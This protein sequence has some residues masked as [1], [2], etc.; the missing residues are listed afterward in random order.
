MYQ[1]V[2]WNNLQFV[3][4]QNQ[5]QFL[6]N[7]EETNFHILSIMTCKIVIDWYVSFFYVHQKKYNNISFVFQN[8]FN[9]FKKYQY[10]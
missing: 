3:L 4:H 6:R 7:Q 9:T 5:F 2:R 10:V 8:I 1:K